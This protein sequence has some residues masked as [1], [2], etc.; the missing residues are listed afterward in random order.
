MNLNIFL[1]TFEK[2][3]K[4]VQR[5]KEYDLRFGLSFEITDTVHN[6]N[7]EFKVQVFNVDGPERCEEALFVDCSEQELEECFDRL[8]RKVYLEIRRDIP[9]GFAGLW[10]KVKSMKDEDA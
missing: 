6:D 10:N 5:Y 3:L 1:P 2:C 8:L 4:K 9:I 7:D